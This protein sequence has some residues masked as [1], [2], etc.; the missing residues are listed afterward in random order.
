MGA[1]RAVGVSQNV[2]L[3]NEQAPAW[4][5]EY[6][7]PNAGTASATGN[8]IATKDGG[9]AFVVAI[10][11]TKLG[12]LGHLTKVD[13]SGAVKFDTE[14]HVNDPTGALPTSTP[15][16][17]L[18]DPAGKYFAILS[19]VLAG[20]QE[21]IM[22]TFINEDG[23]FNGVA[24]FANDTLSVFPSKFVVG[25]HADTFLVAGQFTDANGNNDGFYAEL[26][27]AAG[28]PTFAFSVGSA[29]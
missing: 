13:A 15:L 18:E 16:D 22:L 21:Q 23:T 1:H 26:P 10:N 5:L 27:K 7:Y 2:W 19:N 17:L 4:E 25:A 14:F 28:K 29:S 9:Y 12:V 24:R 8:V 3:H 20:A 11:D 6:A